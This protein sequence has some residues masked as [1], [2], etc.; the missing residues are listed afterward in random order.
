MRFLNYAKIF[1][2]FLFKH[3][4]V[5]KVNL[6]LHRKVV[7]VIFFYFFLLKFFY[8]FNLN[9]DFTFNQEKVIEMFMKNRISVINCIEFKKRINKSKA[10]VITIPNEEKNKV[11]D[12]ELWSQRVVLSSFKQYPKPV[13]YND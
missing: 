4:I 1:K 10:F 9:F 11:F 7:N 5:N 13:E 6:I 2:I 8:C 12:A 3:F